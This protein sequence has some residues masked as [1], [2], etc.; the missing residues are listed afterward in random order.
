MHRRIVA[1]VGLHSEPRRRPPR[2][3]SCGVIELPG[4]PSRVRRSTPVRSYCG[5]KKRLASASAGSVDGRRAAGRSRAVRRSPACPSRR[6]SVPLAG[7][8]SPM[9]ATGSVMP[10]CGEV[11]MRELPERGRGSLRSRPC[12]RVPRWLQPCCPVVDGGAG[13]AD[14][15][16]R[17]PSTPGRG[18]GRSMTPVALGDPSVEAA[19]S[20]H[21]VDAGPL[22]ARRASAA[23]EA[24]PSLAASTL[25][26][27]PAARGAHR[28][29]R[30]PRSR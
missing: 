4:V 19:G 27:C 30:R 22:C 2:R 24:R 8:R 1:H 25:R 13:C 17:P 21:A 26:L 7:T 15:V 10:Q 11:W 20:D 9:I 28:P 3:R 6:F 18:P 16:H 5:R 29:G 12:D 14:S 23:C